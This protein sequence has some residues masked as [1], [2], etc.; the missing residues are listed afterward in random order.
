MSFY[1]L[2]HLLFFLLIV[3]KIRIEVVIVLRVLVAALVRFPMAHHFKLPVSSVGLLFL[4]LVCPQPPM[5][6]LLLLLTL[7]LS[8]LLLFISTVSVR[9]R[10]AQRCEK[11]KENVCIL[12]SITYLNERAMGSRV[13]K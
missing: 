3:T 8:L 2:L 7:L 1:F 4:C 6:L 9:T 5:V 12:C 11:L 10:A 13:N